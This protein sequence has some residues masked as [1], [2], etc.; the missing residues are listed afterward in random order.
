MWRPQEPVPLPRA[1]R[2]FST[3]RRVRLGDVTPKGRLRL[4]ATARYLQ[5][6]ANDDAVDGNYPDIHGWVVRRTEMWV[7][8]FPTYMTDIALTT[9][10]GGY[11]SHWAER[12]THI[13]SPDGAHIE[14]AALWVHVNMQTL[15]PEP[16]PEGFI[17]LIAESSGGRKVRSNFVVGKSLPAI[18]E[19]DPAVSDWQLRFADMDAVGHMNNAAY[20]IATEEY[21]SKHN[22]LR[23]PLHVVVEHHHAIEPGNTVSIVTQ[24]LEERVIVRHV[25]E[26]GVVAA[27]TQLVSLA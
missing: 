8:Q 26:N 6:I 7:Y 27:V 13:V 25:L 10:C 14:T 1:G 23:A 11:G 2:T 4:D 16:L 21:L 9:W 15:K 3:S 19:H 18:T 12:R 20:W 22:T 17:P 5:D 24:Q